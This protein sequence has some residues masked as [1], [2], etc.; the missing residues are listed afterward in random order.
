MERVKHGSIA[1]TDN[2]KALECPREE[3]RKTQK[4]TVEAR[5]G[6]P[7]HLSHVKLHAKLAH[8][9]T[10]LIKLLNLVQ[11]AK[12]RVTRKNEIIDEALVGDEMTR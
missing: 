1:N 3:N 10:R 7:R 9:N 6:H 4:I 11:Q 12:L 8:L 2:L 5:R